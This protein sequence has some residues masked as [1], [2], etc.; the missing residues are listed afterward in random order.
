MR[1]F[2]DLRAALDSVSDE[3]AGQSVRSDT[4]R[5]ARTGTPEVIYAAHKSIEQ[6]LAGIEGLIA[7]RGRVVVSK[8]GAERAAALDEA[9]PDD[10]ALSLAPGNLSGVVFRRESEPP[11]I[12]GRVGVISAGTSDIPVAA[13]A[14]LIAAEMG[15]DVQT[16]W[17]VGV[18]GIHRLIRP[19]EA[20]S[21]WDADVFVVAAGMDGV[22]PSVVSGLVPQPVIG[23]PIS[24]GYGFGG[25]GLGALTTMLQTCSPG[26]AV[27]NIDNGIG[28]GITA[29]RIANRA[30][31]ARRA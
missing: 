28:A 20:M 17:D 10:L 5:S 27:V 21:E 11:G 18:A 23:L 3:S 30:A 7:V 26:I 19:L 16:T 24:S 1:P 2:D 29:A 22:L 31:L 12:G 6:I 8:I 14:A 9:L 15:C 13:E 25:E 4:H